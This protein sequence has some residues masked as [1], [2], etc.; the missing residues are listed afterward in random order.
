MLSMLAYVAGPE[1][2]AVAT[3]KLRVHASRRDAQPSLSGGVH[4][5]KTELGLAEHRLQRTHEDA[6][7]PFAL[8]EAAATLGER[9]DAEAVLAVDETGEDEAAEPAQLTL[10][11]RQDWNQFMSEFVGEF[12]VGA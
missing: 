2:G 6:P 11:L 10:G 7:E 8:N 1:H 4:L 9:F 3:V 12:T 5:L